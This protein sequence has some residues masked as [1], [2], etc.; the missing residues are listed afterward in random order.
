MY[1]AEN[2]P[3]EKHVFLGAEGGVSTGIYESLNVSRSSGDAPENVRKNLEIAAGFLSAVPEQLNLLLQGV[4]NHVE[5]VRTATQYEVEADGAVTDVPGVVLCIR[6]AD[7]APVLF[8]DYEAGVIGAAHAGWRGAFK[9]V[10]ANTIDLMVQKGARR[11]KIAAAVGPCIG[12]ASY[13]VD[14]VFYSQFLEKDEKWSKYFIPSVNEKHYLFDLEK[15]CFD[16]LRDEGLS[17]IT[18]SHLDTY[19]LEGQ[20]FSFRRNT[21]KGIIPA[22]KCFPVELSAI[23][24]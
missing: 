13:E 3:V 15:F 14:D 2:L 24:L 17:N 19:A 4:S 12:Q 11:E 1:K 20:Y 21:H 5:Y 8:A 6:T 18:L 9:G 22:P 23:V 10:I 16:R 7:C